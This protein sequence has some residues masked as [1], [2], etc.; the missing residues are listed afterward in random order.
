MTDTPLPWWDERHAL[1]KNGA[2]E[3]P[4]LTPT[5]AT[6][7]RVPV[8][9]DDDL[10]ATLAVGAAYF[11]G[12]FIAAHRILRYALAETVAQSY[13]KEGGTREAWLARL[14]RLGITPDPRAD[15]D[16]VTYLKVLAGVET[17]PTR[18]IGKIAQ[19]IDAWRIRWE[20]NPPGSNW[21]WPSP[22]SGGGRP[23][24]GT[25]DMT[26]WGRHQPGGSE[27][28]ATRHAKFLRGER[29]CVRCGTP[30]NIVETKGHCPHCDRL[31]QNDAPQ[32]GDICIIAERVED[33]GDTVTAH[34]EH[35]D[36]QQYRVEIYEGDDWETISVKFTLDDAEAEAR[37]HRDQYQTNRRDD[38][39]LPPCGARRALGA[40][41]DDGSGGDDNVVPF[42][43]DEKTLTDKNNAK[44]EPVATPTPTAASS[45]RSD[46]EDDETTD[47]ED[48]TTSERAPPPGVKSW[49]DARFDYETYGPHSNWEDAPASVRKW[50]AADVDN[51][52]N[53]ESFD[54]VGPTN[55]GELHTIFYTQEGKDIG[56]VLL[57]LA[58]DDTVKDALKGVVDV[59]LDDQYAIDDIEEM[60][61]NYEQLYKENEELRAEIKRLKEGRK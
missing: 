1:Y 38:G 34:P 3:R 48:K 30:H 43:S 8:G 13:V 37:V 22:S 35:P 26:C 11:D 25:S 27:G 54:T 41:A 32:Q 17:D 60:I 24:F 4:V 14:E 47:E 45:L 51:A 58:D 29:Q 12:M 61:K 28:I 55:I 57:A 52:D 21:L 16:F 18:R 53:F 46:A 6:F 20:Q 23:S 39:S 19:Y 9:I 33:G 40:Q 5:G 50:L 2:E 59:F 31:T 7:V 36:A 15:N 10:A 49:K 44:S 56:V 42:R